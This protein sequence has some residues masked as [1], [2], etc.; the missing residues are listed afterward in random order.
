ME[1]TNISKKT[2]IILFIIPLAVVIGILVYFVIPYFYVHHDKS[3]EANLNQQLQAEK[4]SSFN[5]SDYIDYEWSNAYT[6]LPYTEE[7]S[8]K[9]ILGNKFHDPV[10]MEL[11][12]DIILMV[13]V[14]D[15][16]TFE[17]AKIQIGE[18]GIP[19]GDNTYTPEADVIE[20]TNP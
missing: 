5:L 9:E 19:L 15:D 13:V 16:K 10:G 2:K 3:L 20:V 14:K 6:F 18:N 17:Y 1:Q 12:D 7:S 11:R 8:M 4:S